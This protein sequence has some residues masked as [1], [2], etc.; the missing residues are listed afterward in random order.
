MNIRLRFE[1]EGPVK[2]VGHLDM[3]RYFQ[4]AMKR[5]N[6]D[7]CYSEGFNPHQIMSFAVPL[8]VGITSKG[9]YID[10]AV[11]STRSSAESID[12]LNAVMAEGVKISGYRLLPDNAVNAMASVAAASYRVVSK[13]PFST[14]FSFDKFL[15]TKKKWFDEASELMV[16]KPTKKSEV[17][18]DLKKLVYS[19]EI[20]VEEGCPVFDFFLSQGS[21]DNLKPQFVMEKLYEEMGLPFDV[22][23]FYI[24]RNDIYTRIDEKFVSLGDIGEEIV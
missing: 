1:K 11:N 13:K 3:M 6:M 19:F 12:A 10:I 8:G 22:L 21:M 7:M 4:K 16:T 5:A 18:L 2:Y 20:S 15:D 23:D 17:E 24:H 9:E 14:E